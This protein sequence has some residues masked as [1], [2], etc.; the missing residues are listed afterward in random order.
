MAGHS[1][2]WLLASSPASKVPKKKNTNAH[3]VQQ[4]HIKKQQYTQ[5]NYNN[6][7]KD[8]LK[9]A[10]IHTSQIRILQHVQKVKTPKQDSTV[11]SLL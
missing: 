3:T 6:T 7:H 5:D 11:F 1:E 9:Q 2:Y 8:N 4:I 10:A